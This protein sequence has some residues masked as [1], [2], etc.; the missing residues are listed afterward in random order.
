M[1][2]DTLSESRATLDHHPRNSSDITLD[3]GTV[4]AFDTSLPHRF[5]RGSVQQDGFGLTNVAL[6]ADVLEPDR[7]R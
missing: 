7:R 5:D 6:S 2:V 4:L 1:T 3:R